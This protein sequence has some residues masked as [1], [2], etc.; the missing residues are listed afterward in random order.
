MVQVA[1][2]TTVPWLPQP[3]TSWMVEPLPSSMRHQPTGPSVLGSTC[4]EAARVSV[5][6][7]ASVTRIVKR[8]APSVI[9]VPL[10][11]PV[12]ALRLSPAGSVPVVTAQ[13][14]GVAPPVAVSVC[15]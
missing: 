2:A 4:S 12:D 9:G 14:Y 8:F 15:E 13:A 10:I 11:S 7:A 3:D 6:L 5:V 1:S